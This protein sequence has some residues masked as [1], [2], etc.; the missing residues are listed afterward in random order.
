MTG[1]GQSGPAAHE[2]G[3]DLNYLAMSGAARSIAREGE[4]PVPP[5]N[6]IADYGGGLML[7]YGIGLALFERRAS[8]RGQVIDAAMA[9][10]ALLLMSGLWQR[11]A[12]GRWSPVPGTNDMDSGAPFYN[13]YRTSDGH[14][15]AVGSVEPRFYANLLRVLGLPDELRALQHDRARWSETKRRIADVFATKTRSEWTTLFAG[16]EACVTPVNAVEEVASDPHVR[17]R[18]MILDQNGIQ[19][20]AAAPRL[21]RTEL[22]LSDSSIRP[23]ALHDVVEQWCSADA[24]PQPVKEGM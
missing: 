13:S 2:P 14:Y 15:M 12:E 5:L 24:I 23:R 18:A 22:K 11:K 10:A 1:W 8:G 21:S 16:A 20:P 6:M 9:D 19:F 7:A 4:D 17:A 3:H